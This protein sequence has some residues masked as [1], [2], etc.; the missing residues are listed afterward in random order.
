MHFIST[1]ILRY[2]KV[3]PLNFKEQLSFQLCIFSACD[4]HGVYNISTIDLAKI[5]ILVDSSNNLY[6]K[7]N[8]TL[9]TN[10]YNVG[11]QKRT[12]VAYIYKTH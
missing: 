9:L 7:P 3:G 5:R 10:C 12:Q 11:N 4:A 8:D 6:C 2:E 1:Y